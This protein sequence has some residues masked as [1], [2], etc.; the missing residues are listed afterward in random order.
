MKISG[1]PSSSLSNM[2]ICYNEMV[3]IRISKV[4]LLIAF[5]YRTILSRLNANKKLKNKEVSRNWLLVYWKI[6][7]LIKGINEIS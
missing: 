6:R 4:G 3:E 7:Y 1:N 5:N 2:Q